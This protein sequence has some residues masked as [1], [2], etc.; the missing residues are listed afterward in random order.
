MAGTAPACPLWTSR[1]T[2]VADSAG[3]VAAVGDGVTQLRVGD[4][5]TS[6]FYVSSYAR[7]ALPVI[8]LAPPSTVPERASLPSSRRPWVRTVAPENT[9]LERR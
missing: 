7:V 6:H 3:V 1:R 9:G 5:V 8:A 4:R 2:P